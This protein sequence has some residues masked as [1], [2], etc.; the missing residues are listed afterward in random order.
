FQ[1]LPLVSI[2]RFVLAVG[3]AP[4]IRKSRRDLARKQSTEQRV[5]RVRRRRR[6]YRVVVRRLDV[7]IGSE[8][9]L[10]RAPLVESEAIDDDEHRCL[11][12]LENRQQKLGDD[13]DREWW[14]IAVEVLEPRRI[15]ALDVRRE[16]A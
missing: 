1:E 16:L 12:A 6:Q 15:V 3:V 4:P 9:R 13:V 11:V 7:E 14:P 2:E 8:Q 5:T 10:Q